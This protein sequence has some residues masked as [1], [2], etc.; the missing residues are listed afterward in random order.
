[1][2]DLNI[3]FA[4]N[5]ALPLCV[6]ATGNGYEGYLTIQIDESKLEAFLVDYQSLKKAGEAECRS[7]GIAPSPDMVSNFLP[8]NPEELD[9]FDEFVDSLP[10]EVRD[11]ILHFDYD[12]EAV[13]WAESVNRFL[14]FGRE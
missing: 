4:F 9:S 7:H 5:H 3:H 1:M 10:E 2:P 6:Y 13:E 12:L 14:Q 8:R 11:E